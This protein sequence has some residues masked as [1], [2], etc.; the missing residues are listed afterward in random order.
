[1]KLFFIAPTAAPGGIQAYNI[2]S[3]VLEVAWGEVPFDGRNGQ[4]RSFVIYYKLMGA[5]EK[6][7]KYTKTADTVNKTMIFGLRHWSFY[8]IK[9]S[10]KT[11]EEGVKS[12]A[13][14]ARTDEDGNFI[15]IIVHLNITRNLG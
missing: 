2:S 10:A 14:I 1:M 8:E 12:D 5:S 3:T 11:V 15:K 13:V 6:D 7:W 9:I 4:I